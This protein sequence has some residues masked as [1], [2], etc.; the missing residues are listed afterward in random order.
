[1]YSSHEILL[2]Q[3]FGNLYRTSMDAKE[4]LTLKSEKFHGHRFLKW[5][6]QLEAW[7]IALGLIIAIGKRLPYDVASSSSRSFD[8]SDTSQIDKSP[9]EI[10][11]HC[12]FEIL[13][14]LSND[15]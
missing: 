3:V 5:W 15:L 9:K 10:E 1:M 12:K 4:T 7:L 13:S 6:E 2:N 14:C 8:S 11:F